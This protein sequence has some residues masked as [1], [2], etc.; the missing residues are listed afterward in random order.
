[1]TGTF[2]HRQSDRRTEAR[3]FGSEAGLRGAKG[4]F[5]LRS[6][7]YY[8]EFKGFIFRRNG[9]DSRRGC[10]QPRP[11]GPGGDE[12]SGLSRSA[13][14]RSAAANSSSSGKW[15]RHGESTWGIDGEHDLVRATFADGTMC[16]D[17]PPQRVGEV[18]RRDQIGRKV[19]AAR[20]AQNNIATTGETPTA[21][22]NLPQAV[23]TPSTARRP[24]SSS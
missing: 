7:R 4:P 8:T 19:F 24:A 3:Q 12:P 14:R 13:T 5:R 22:Y 20:L 18:V 16:R 23:G 17:I 9:R 11:G 15:R 10:R 21:G 6:H 2:E 1:M